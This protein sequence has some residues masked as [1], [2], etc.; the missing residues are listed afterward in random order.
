M[1]R[2]SLLDTV[3]EIAV[4]ASIALFCYGATALSGAGLLRDFFP[5]G[6]SPRWSGIFEQHLWQFIL[7]FTAIGYLSRGHLWSYGINSNNLKSSMQ[8]LGALYVATMILS[9]VAFIAGREL[10]PAVTVGPSERFDDALFMMLIQWMSSPVANQILFFGFAQTL[11]LKT[12]RPGNKAVTVPLSILLSSLLYT[13]L[14]TG[15]PSG[16]AG[17]ALI[18]SF[19]LALYCGI[20]YWKTGSLITPMLGQ[21]FFFGFPLFVSVVHRLVFS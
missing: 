11:M 17:S 9:A 7:A 13:F 3:K 19:I 4:V 5:S 20:V 21:A 1:N 18:P 6:V 8:W 14:A 16:G 15:I 2:N 12:L 10:I